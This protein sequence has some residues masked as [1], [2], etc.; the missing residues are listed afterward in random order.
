MQIHS[1]QE[2]NFW[3]WYFH[4]QSWHLFTYWPGSRS[5]SFLEL[6]IDCGCRRRIRQLQNTADLV[7]CQVLVYEK[8]PALCGWTLQMLKSCLPCPGPFLHDVLWSSLRWCATNVLRNV[9]EADT[10]AGCSK[11]VKKQLV[12]S[13]TDFSSCARQVTD[14][15]ESLWNNNLPVIVDE[16]EFNF[17][18]HRHHRHRGNRTWLM[19]KCRMRVALP[20]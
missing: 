17:R 15:W 16:N 4:V 1:T 11:R 19:T 18:H 5:W 3:S 20:C 6:G 7:Q 12:T 13:H 9:C 10:G 2:I 8:F 14:S